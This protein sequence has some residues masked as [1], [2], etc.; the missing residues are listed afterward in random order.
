MVIRSSL[1]SISNRLGIFVQIDGANLTD[2]LKNS[3]VNVS[4]DYEVD[5]LPP[6]CSITMSKVGDWVRRSN[7]VTV[8]TQYAGELPET[9]FTGKVKRVRR[10]DNGGTVDC[11]GLTA[12]LTRQFRLQSKT[13]TNQTQTA[14]IT[15]ILDELPEPI[16]YDVSLIAGGINIGAVKSA[17]LDVMTMSDMVRKIADIDGHRMFELPSGQLV[18]RSLF[19]A[20]ASRPVRRYTTGIQVP[21]DFSTISP[22]PSTPITTDTD[23]SFGNAAATERAAQEIIMPDALGDRVETID[24]R[25]KSVGSPADNIEV[26]MYYSTNSEKHSADFEA[27]PDTEKVYSKVAT[28][29]NS[30][31][32]GSYQTINVDVLADDNFAPQ[33]TRLWFTV[34]RSGANDAVNYYQIE[35]DSTG[36]HATNSAIYSSTSTVWTNEG[37]GANLA[38]FGVNLHQAL[39]PKVLSISDDEDEDQIKKKVYVRGTTLE[40]TNAEGDATQDLIEQVAVTYRSDLVKGDPEFYSMVYQNSLIDSDL[41]AAKTALRLLDKYHRVIETIEIAIPYDPGIRLGQ[42]IFID[43]DGNN[44]G[45]TIGNTGTWWIAGYQHNLGAA[46]AET[47]LSL[48]GGDQ[49]GTV[50]QV[51]PQADFVFTQT[52]TPI[53]AGLRVNVEYRSTSADADGFITNYAWTDTYSGTGINI[54]SGDA[55]VVTASYDPAVDEDFTVTLTVTDNDG[56]TAT[57]TKAITLDFTDPGNEP[58]LHVPIIACA[59]GNTA[60]TTVDGGLSWNDVASPSGDVVTCEATFR[61]TVD[62]P[63]YIFFGTDTGRV[64]R[65]DD[66]G[67]T[68]ELVLDSGSS[69]VITDIV[70]D[71]QNRNNIWVLTDVGIVWLSLLFGANGTF[72]IYGGPGASGAERHPQSTYRANV[73]AGSGLSKTH[74]FLSKDGIGYHNKLILSPNKVFIFGGR[75]DD[76]ESFM[77]FNRFGESGFKWYSA[78]IFGDG[79][80][81]TTASDDTVHVIDAAVSD[82]LTDITLVFENRNLPAIHSDDWTRTPNAGWTNVT[83]L[84]GVDDAV[85]VESNDSQSGDFHVALDTND[86]YEATDGVTYVV[87]SNVAPG[88][89]AN[90]WRSILQLAGQRDMFIAGTDEGIGISTDAGATWDFIRPSTAPTPNTTWPANAVGHDLA[91]EYRTPVRRNV[92]AI[93]HNHAAP[94]DTDVVSRTEAQGWV[95][96]EDLGAFIEDRWRLYHFPGVDSSSPSDMSQ[97]VFRLRYSG[98][99]TTTWQDLYRSTNLGVT[100]PDLELSNAGD[101]AISPDGSVWATHGASSPNV[102]SRSTDGGATWVTEHTVTNGSDPNKARLTRIRVDPNDPNH[103]MACGMQDGT[104]DSKLIFLVSD[105]ALAGS[106]TW[107]RITHPN[108]LPLQANPESDLGDLWLLAGDAR[109]WIVGYTIDNVTNHRYIAYSDNNGSTWTGGLFDDSG[110]DSI[111]YHAIRGGNVLYACGHRTAQSWVYRST[112]NGSTWEQIATDSLHPSALAYQASTNTLY[113]GGHHEANAVS[114]LVPPISGTPLRDVT[115]DLNAVTSYTDAHVN[116][117]GLVAMS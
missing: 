12:A 14:A 34:Q 9:V 57:T 44:D 92:L 85:G 21:A 7:N 104:D 62:G 83:G 53:G 45:V 87:A 20:P 22:F 112:D 16:D 24:L 39:L 10:D 93:V 95:L 77:I 74:T 90:V 30:A 61:G 105:D 23:L 100:F 114:R 55:R 17:V 25:I 101:V 110:S 40:T 51:L 106:P 108:Y 5:Q 68:L 31:I 36:S 15:N 50:G 47:T 71:R 65:S 13:F 41:Q 63:N 18:I 99:S 69:Q 46:N 117:E 11:V 73:P 82:G 4:I 19:E 91:I 27:V 111:W 52:Q 26:N 116:A 103:V 48:F 79:V 64:Y 67:L 38:G 75:G 102:I 60:M 37:D 2:N 66:N 113:I 6:T 80:G 86:W 96:G 72:G 84:S 32:S 76:V 97:V 28:I 35:R 49:S 43:D 1:T 8:F 33:G 58:Q 88:T 94:S 115:D 54:S 29:P 81:V 107:S 42:S 3:Y 56:N 70:A 109:R 59:G 78:I 89:G 98:S